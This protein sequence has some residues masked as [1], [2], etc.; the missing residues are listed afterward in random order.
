MLHSGG[1][2]PIS[3]SAYLCMLW[4]IRGHEY[5]AGGNDLSGLLGCGFGWLQPGHHASGLLGGQET[6]FCCTDTIP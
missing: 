4:G 5:A 3:K 6:S 1:P 2:W